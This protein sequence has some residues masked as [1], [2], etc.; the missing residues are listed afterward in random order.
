MA[1]EKKIVNEVGT[2]RALNRTALERIFT[3]IV[4]P[5]AG[6]PRSL[7]L[8][9]RHGIGKSATVERMAKRSAKECNRSYV[10][11]EQI[12]ANTIPYAGASL[13][14]DFKLRPGKIQWKPNEHY[15]FYDIRV[16]QRDF[17]DFVG[18]ISN[19]SGVTRFIPVDWVTLYS[20]PDAAGLLFFDE[21]DRGTK[22]V[23]NAV[24]E[25]VLDRRINDSKFSNS[26]GIV[27]AGNSGVG[28][29]D[30]YD[31]EPMDAALTSRFTT[32]VFQPSVAEW[33]DWCRN[34]GGTDD[35]GN[36]V[37]SPGHM[38]VADFIESNQNLLD[39][40]A[41]EGSFQRDDILPT[42]RGWGMVA[43]SVSSVVVNYGNAGN[44]P[45]E[46]VSTLASGN[47]GDGVGAKFG[48]WF[49]D[50]RYLTFEDVIR[51]LYKPGRKVTPAEADG[52][53]K[54]M[55]RP[56]KLKLIL[57]YNDK[58][59]PSGTKE[60]IL[61]IAKFFEDAF[62]TSSE[63]GVS[64]VKVMMSAMIG[65]F[66]K[67]AKMIFGMKQPARGQMEDGP[68]SHLAAINVDH[69]KKS[70]G[71]INFQPKYSEYAK[72]LMAKRAEDQRRLDERKK[73]KSAPT[74]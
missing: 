10:K 68:L 62:A 53:A 25:A 43:D 57:N 72:E 50:N 52:I 5:V 14:S 39:F 8:R 19:D 16:A 24:F 56:E 58:N 36:F 73:A 35:Q 67:E 37:H 51:G 7:M 38:I 1:K 60:E 11:F 49:S 28:M 42:R 66:A 59:E 61:E 21:V 9:G 46:I 33:L 2:V 31:S 63:V 22:L 40:D 64:V 34:V 20:H 26:V 70:G 17:V 47:V 30:L 3:H 69:V 6:T 48:Q 18:S 27:A 13:P 41:D 15:V 4:H 23:R 45:V 65:N 71:L 44:V 32:Y 12:D 54:D 74:T 55:M 29:D